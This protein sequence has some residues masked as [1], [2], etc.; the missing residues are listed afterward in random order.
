MCAFRR[1]VQI[2][3]GALLM[4]LQCAAWANSYVDVLDLPAKLSPLA[5]K[6]PLQDVVHA[7]S[8]LVAV[9]QRGHILYSDDAGQN[10]RQARVPVSVDLNAVH[11]PTAEQGWAV[12]ND[13]VI[14]HSRD[15]GATWSLQLDGRAIGRLLIEHYGQLARQ[16]PGDERWSM[17]VEEGRRLDE[18]GA[19]KPFLDVWFANARQGYAVGVFNLILA[20]ADGGQTWVP[21]QDRI[22]NPQGLHLNAINSTGD[23]LYIAGEQGLLQ[24]WDEA[25]G[26]FSAVSSPYAGSFFGVTGK[27]GGEVLVYGLRGHAYLSRDGGQTWQAL[28]TD[29]QVSVTAATQDPAGRYLLFTQAGHKLLVEERRSALSVQPQDGQSP[30]G[31]AVLAANGQLILVGVRGV[32][33]LPAE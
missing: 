6:S 15:G 30:V 24:K 3:A 29:L 9:G 18:Q 12:G 28:Q 5:V 10:W 17:L 11:F 13:G 22:D 19:D 31:A 7:G 2:A 14:L 20:T 25:L 33:A 23:A 27:P 26:R 1:Y 21:F 8:R 4:L 16:Q 32:R